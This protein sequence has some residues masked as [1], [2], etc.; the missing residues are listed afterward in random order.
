MYTAN[1]PNINSEDHSA[2]S[3]PAD[4]SSNLNTVDTR[5]SSDCSY[6]GITHI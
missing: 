2:L 6:P 4:G 5:Q 1:V 3:M